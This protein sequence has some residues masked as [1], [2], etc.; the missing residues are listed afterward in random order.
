M[1]TAILIAVA[2]GST[3]AGSAFAQ[4]LRLDP[5]SAALAKN[6]LLTVQ[7]DNS[8]KQAQ[9]DADTGH[10]SQVTA[11]TSAGSDQPQKPIAQNVFWQGGVATVLVQM[12]DG[13]TRFVSPGVVFADHWRARISGK[14]AVIEEATV[15]TRKEKKRGR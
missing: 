13:T 3:I 6:M 2:L 10:S 7:K 1:R 14:D 5:L 8:D 12:P 9:I 4:E 15:A 11:T